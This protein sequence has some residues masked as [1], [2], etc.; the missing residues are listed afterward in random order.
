MGQVRG[1]GGWIRCIRRAAMSARLPFD[2]A[3]ILSVLGA[4]DVAFIVIGGVAVQAWGH[5]RT[6]RDL[7]LLIDPRPANLARLAAA[8]AELEAELYT[9]PREPDR[10]PLPTDPALLARKASWNLFTSAGGLDLW[11]DTTDLAGARGSYDE[12]AGRAQQVEL[13]SATI[14]IVGRDDLIAM[15]RVAARSRD[16]DD[17][18]ALTRVRSQTPR[19]AKPVRR[20]PA[21]A[22]ASARRPSARARTRGTALPATLGCPTADRRTRGSRRRSRRHWRRCP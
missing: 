4:H 15:K 14:A 10:L 7:D 9:R 20:R 22:R 19:D 13:A 1:G 6:T 21:P 17:I 2:P 18:A 12:L 16:L 3:Q 11:I 5:Q 8:L